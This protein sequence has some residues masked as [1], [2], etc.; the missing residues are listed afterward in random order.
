M[1]DI[2]DKKILVV[3]DDT[4][5]LQLLANTF[6]QTGAQVYIA[7]GGEEGLRQFYVH[8]P[9][10]VIL[11]LMMPDISG[12]Q[13]C[14]RIRQ[15]SDVPIIFLS[16]IGGDDNVI[17]GLNGGA[18]DYVVKPFSPDVLKA[19]AG[20]VLRQAVL[21]TAAEKPAA[22]ADDYLTIDLE[23]HQV[24]VRGEPVKLTATE[25]RLLGYLVRNADQ[26]LTFD[27]ILENVWGWEYRESTNYIHVYLSHLRQKLEEDPKEPRYLL[28]E[29]GVG[30][31]FHKPTPNH[32]TFPTAEDPN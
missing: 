31:Q 10:L 3:D 27:Q 25:Y 23:T 1:S 11:D 20:A 21:S 30:Y 16:A 22:Y 5:L 13:V 26:V 8:R 6:S 7:N 32:V 28:T 12:W 18:V 19:R 29:H 24:L 4:D 17:Q 15:K 2:Q 14:S 9:D